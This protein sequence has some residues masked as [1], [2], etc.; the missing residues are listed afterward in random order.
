MHEQQSAAAVGEKS[1]RAFHSGHIHE[2][3]GWKRWLLFWPMAIGLRLYYATLRFRYLPEE[4]SAIRNCPVP[5]VMLCWHNR[6]LVIPGFLQYAHPGHRLIGLVSASKMAAWE[7]AF[8]E[9]VGIG[10]IRGSSTRRSIAA[11]RELLDAHRDGHDLGLSPDGPSGPLYAMKRGVVMLARMTGAP[12][13]LISCNSSSAHRPGTW[14]RHF[15]PL[16]FSRVNVRYTLIPNYAALG[17]G[18]D[19]DDAAA[20]ILREKLLAITEDPFTLPQP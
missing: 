1:R 12:L 7:A 13:L 19:D 17:V 18:P 16:P 14:D 5:V 15:I 3:K 6:S 8:F 4:L 20:R 11:T 2:I 10:C 9:W